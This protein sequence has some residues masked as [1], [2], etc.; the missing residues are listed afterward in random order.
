MHFVFSAD[1]AEQFFDQPDGCIM[2][3]LDN[4]TPNEAHRCLESAG[5]GKLNVKF[6]SRIEGEL[7]RCMH[8]PDMSPIEIHPGDAIHVEERQAIQYVASDKQVLFSGAVESLLHPQ[9]TYGLSVGHAFKNVGEFGDAVS[10]NG[11]QVGVCHEVVANIGSTIRCTAD[12]AF[13]RLNETLQ[14][15]ENILT[16]RR[17]SNEDCRRYRLKIFPGN[18]ETGMPVTIVN[19]S[20][21]GRDGVIGIVSFNDLPKNIYS[22]LKIIGE[23]GNTFKIDNGDCGALVVNR[24]SSDESPASNDPEELFVIGIVIGKWNG[25]RPDSEWAMANRI[26][27]VLKS[28]GQDVQLCRKL[29]ACDPQ[30]TDL[31]FLRH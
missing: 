18:I 10:V 16:I 29:F 5:F 21:I 11:R 27:D 28:I 17:E 4:I 25:G 1:W 14:L 26:K 8:E 2:V 22:T 13:L 12:L 9:S 19:S 3:A 20:G 31:D 30:V 6:T 15:A 24:P 23:D 7:V